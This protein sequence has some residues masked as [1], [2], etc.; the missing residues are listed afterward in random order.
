MAGA[1]LAAL[2]AVVCFGV[3]F[4][5][6]KVQH[7]IGAGDPLSLGI[8]AAVAA[9]VFGLSLLRTIRARTS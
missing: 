7:G 1:V 5:I 6:E 2:A 3:A 9:A 4:D 8:A